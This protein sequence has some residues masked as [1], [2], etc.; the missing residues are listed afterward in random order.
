[1]TRSCLVV[2]ASVLNHLLEQGD[3]DEVCK[4]IQRQGREIRTIQGCV[5]E[6]GGTEAIQSVAVGR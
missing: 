6:R 4:T 1:M 5:Q 2:A 3:D